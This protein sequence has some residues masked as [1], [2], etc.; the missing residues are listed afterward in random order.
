MARL[1]HR[2]A[3]DKVVDLEFVN[4]IIDMLNEISDTLK[5]IVETEHETVVTAANHYVCSC[6]ARYLNLGDKFRCMA[7]H[8]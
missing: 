2:K 7:T 6:G 5:R 4:A 3:T 8:G 1:V